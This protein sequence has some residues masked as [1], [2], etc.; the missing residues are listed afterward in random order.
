MDGN[1]PSLQT[2]GSRPR[3]YGP[4]VW[5]LVGVVLLSVL[6]AAAGR[7]VA[8]GVVAAIVVGALAVRMTR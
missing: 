1:W 2:T 6:Y 5:I 8:A 7:T 4:S 3:A